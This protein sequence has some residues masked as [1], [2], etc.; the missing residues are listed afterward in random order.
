MRLKSFILTSLLLVAFNLG[1]GISYA[2]DS[3]LA[4]LF[5][6]RGV[7]GTIVISSLDGRIEYVHDSVRSETRFVPASTFKIL[8]T[9]IAL[10]EGVVK[11]EKE[12]IKWDGKDKGLM[13]WNK[14]QTI[15]TAFPTSCVWF[16]QELARRIGREKY[17]IHL[18][19]LEYGNEKAGPEVTSF[20][21]EGNGHIR[22]GA[23]RIP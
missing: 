10:Q 2:D 17:A 3:A 22:E 16:Y 23:D 13:E 6:D 15:E 9:L 19:R 21:L 4:K 18:K 14:D 1:D 12:V 8:N 20:W 7:I 5:E 11:D